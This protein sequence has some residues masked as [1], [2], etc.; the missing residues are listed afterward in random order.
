MN[1]PSTDLDDAAL[2]A[3]YCGGADLARRDEA[4]ALIVARHGAMVAATCRRWLSGGEAEDAVQAVFV[5]LA[6][7]ASEIRVGAA[8]PG[9][10][11][12]TAWNIAQRAASASKARRIHE[13]K[14]AQQA[15]SMPSHAAAP[16]PQE[17]DLDAALVR[18]PETYRTPLV[19]H[20]F[21]G[22][23]QAEVAQRLGLRENAVA[24][25]LSRGRSMLREHL[26]RLGAPAAALGLFLAVA[27][28]LS[29]AESTGLGRMAAAVRTGQVPGRVE[30]LTAGAAASAAVGGT[31]LF[32][33][34][35]TLAALVVG[36]WLAYP[37]GPP[38]VPSSSATSAPVAVPGAW[39]TQLSMRPTNFLHDPDGRVCVSAN[40]AIQWF[41]PDGSRIFVQDKDWRG[42]R[43]FVGSTILLGGR[44]GED[45]VLRA[46]DM[47][48]NSEIWRR[49]WPMGTF[50]EP[51]ISVIPPRSPDGAIVALVQTGHPK[52]HLLV[53]HCNGQ[54]IASH[55]VSTSFFLRLVGGPEGTFW[56]TSD[57][58]LIARHSADGS[59]LWNTTVGGGGEH[60][61]PLAD[62]SLVIR[63]TIHGPSKTYDLNMARLGPDGSVCWRQ[64]YPFHA[65]EIA[66]HPDGIFFAGIKRL[67]IVGKDSLVG[68]CGLMDV[69]NGVVRWQR[70]LPGQPTGLCVHTKGFATIASANRLNCFDAQGNMVAERELESYQLLRADRHGR[71][72]VM[73]TPSDQD[74]N[75][76]LIVLPDGWW[77]QGAQGARDF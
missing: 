54:E 38:V 5:V 51:S 7:K 71:T 1:R 56:Y 45:A 63:F 60:S 15:A 18:L 29:S 76:R 74:K 37:I 42:V 70:P 58:G 57:D 6:R 43:G 40:G 14:A 11:H 32:I 4:F 33:G 16:A 26:E 66:E 64:S 69:D 50:G 19:L 21:E 39:E 59:V 31:A 48:T 12:Q 8:L 30:V 46:V 2:L 65:T 61:A 53:L 75:S 44:S 22:L 67:N 9:W 55:E 13:S 35:L 47:G 20:Y 77:R 68:L 49:T 34:V 52:A 17:S 36:A 23:P 24:M 10:L 72:I 62:G 73:S 25:R 28:P 41:A 3:S 27:P